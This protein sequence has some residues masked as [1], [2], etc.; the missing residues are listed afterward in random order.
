M[1]AEVFSNLNNPF[2]D[3]AGFSMN[4]YVYVHYSCII[5]LRQATK[6]ILVTTY[7]VS[8]IDFSHLTSM[9]S[10]IAT[11]FSEKEIIVFFQKVRRTKNV[12]VLRS[13]TLVKSRHIYSKKREK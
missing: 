11:S 8:S 5:N 3:I 10:T 13:T 12:L 4:K 1:I 6:L 2:P 7:S 9:I